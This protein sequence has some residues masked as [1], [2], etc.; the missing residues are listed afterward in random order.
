MR[1]TINR[2]FCGHTPS[3]CESCFGEFLRHGAIPDRGCITDAVDD[4]KP[5]LTVTIFSGKYSTTLTIPPQDFE[6][7]MYDGWMKYADLPAEAYDILP[8]R[9]QDIRRMLKESK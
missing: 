3:A 7:V 5:E 6:K 2:N 4:Q 9:V 8:P 1:V